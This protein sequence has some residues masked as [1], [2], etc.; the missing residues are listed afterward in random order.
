MPDA[1]TVPS[2]QTIRDWLIERVAFY[3]ERAP[4]AVDPDVQIVELGLDSVY[5]LN[6]C[7]DIEDEFGFEVEPTLGWDHPTVNA[8]TAFLIGELGRR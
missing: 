1:S 4:D 2:E 6:L 3:T 7:G 8:I 5:A